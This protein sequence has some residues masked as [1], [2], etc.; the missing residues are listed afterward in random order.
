MKLTVKARLILGFGLILL[1]MLAAT[2]LAV[3][4]LAGIDERIDSVVNFSAKKAQLADKINQNLLEISRAEKNLILAESE[5]KKSNYEKFINETKSEMQSG[6]EELRNLADDAGKAD[7]DEF[8]QV[9]DEYLKNEQE[10]ARLGKLNSNIKAREISQN[11][12]QDAYDKAMTFLANIVAH[13][14][15]EADHA[16]DLSALESATEKI[17]LTGKVNEDFLKIQAT[18]KNLVIAT[19]QDEV[20]KYDKAIGETGKVMESRVETLEK[21]LSA[22]GK[23]NLLQFSKAYDEYMTINA[24][25][26]ELSKENGN[27]RAFVLSSGKGREL[28]DKAEGLMAV[29]VDKNDKAMEQDKELSDRN[30]IAARNSLIVFMA[31]AIALGLGLASWIIIVINQRL[32]ELKMGADNVADASLEM[33]STSEEMSQGAAEQAAAAEEASASIEEMSSSIVQNADNS[34]QTEAIAIKA[35]DDAQKSGEAVAETVNAM[36]Q[37]AEKI[38]II[39][40]I[41]RQ[42]NLLALNA[43]IEAARAGEHGKGFA[44]VAAEVRKLAERSQ[45]AAAEINE[46]SGSSMEVAERAGRMLERMVPDIQK[47]AALV[48]EISA[49]SKEQST[50]TEQISQA[51]QQLEQVIQQNAGAS[52]EMAATA[53]EL[54]SQAEQMRES[55]ADLIKS[56]QR[57]TTRSPKFSGSGLKGH[58]NQLKGGIAHRE[59]T[60]GKTEKKEEGVFLKLEHDHKKGIDKDFERY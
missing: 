47:T 49:A 32:M 19:R 36:K 1:L 6:Q 11:E 45:S 44:V 10:V 16:K 7:L 56:D 15:Q 39:E 26:R 2:F 21:M 50:G 5:E 48:Q 22:Q 58:L 52:E 34:Q 46:L 51:I 42:T 3:G 13:N 30:Y 9:W 8:K 23:E 54:S 29:I 24:K 38:S 35:A 59:P 27:T 40:E 43:A 41:A 14:E 33:S 53:E 17:K 12:G 60:G 25:V 4:K 31:V 55:I 28:A 18:E 20:E 57:R 37:I